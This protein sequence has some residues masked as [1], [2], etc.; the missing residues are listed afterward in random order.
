MNEDPKKSI[1]EKIHACRSLSTEK[2][3]ISNLE[4]LLNETGNGLVSYELG[5][6]YEKIG[7][8]KEAIQYYKKA[9]ALFTQINHKNM[10]LAAINNI[11]I[12]DLI[13]EKKK[14]DKK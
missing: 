9:E 1:S 12:E 11:T 14:E 13:V 10:A 4:E 2:Q 3:L 8:I 6:E 5:H 7:K